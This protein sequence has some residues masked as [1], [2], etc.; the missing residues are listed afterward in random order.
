MSDAT[1][2]AGANAA[3]PALAA[4]AVAVHIAS[5]VFAPVSVLKDAKPT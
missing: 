2:A 3:A 1:V 5:C 4:G